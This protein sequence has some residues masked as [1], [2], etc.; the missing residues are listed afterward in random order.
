[1]NAFR[2]AFLVG[3]ACSFCRCSCD[4]LWR[5]SQSNTPLIQYEAPTLDPS[6]TAEE[7]VVMT[8]LLRFPPDNP[9]RHWKGE[10]VPF[11]SYAEWAA[12]GKQ[13]QGA[14][15]TILR[16]FTS[17]K[18][19]MSDYVVLAALVEVGTDKSI[20]TVVR[21]LTE[22]AWT[23]GNSQAKNCAILFFREHHN[24]AVIECLLEIVGS[25]ESVEDPGLVAGAVGTL[26]QIGDE[27]AIPAIE[28]LLKSDYYTQYP[29][30]YR[31]R[32]S[33]YLSELRDAG[34]R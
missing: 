2:R 33:T 8:W 26:A 21:W 19:P 34:E 25:R 17:E 28:Q 23:V 1:M 7:R 6:L 18:I 30:W 3:M 31:A 16:L 15:E 29:E 32:I 22:N 24:D 10:P 13:I 27:R 11:S 9:A 20:E 12:A 4:R 5:R 14:E